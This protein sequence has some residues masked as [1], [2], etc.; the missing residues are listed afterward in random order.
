MLNV[1][2]SR[3]LIN[4][5]HRTDLRFLEISQMIQRQHGILLVPQLW[6]PLKKSLAKTSKICSMDSNETYNILQEKAEFNRAA[7]TKNK[8]GLSDTLRNLPV[9]NVK[10]STKILQKRLKR[11]S[12]KNISVP[13][14]APSRKCAAN[15]KTITAHQL[16]IK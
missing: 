11:T 10:I 3:R 15:H 12:H 13:L 9:I 16:P 6:G 7:T 8:I 5:T 1:T 14:S 2:T 4:W